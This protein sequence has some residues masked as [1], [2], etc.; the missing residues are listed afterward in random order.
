MQINRINRRKI[1]IGLR[2]LVFAALGMLCL[3]PAA[4]EQ[5]TVNGLFQDKAIVT[6]DGRQRVL[7]KGKKSP[8]GALLIEANSKRAI[9]EIDGERK[10]YRMGSSRIG[11]NFKKSASGEKI[12]LL[13]DASGGYSVTGSIN[14]SAVSFI[15]DTG[16]TLVSM[17]SNVA[18]RLGI[19]F[20]LIGRESVSLTASGT[21]KIYIVNLRKVRV[22][23]IEL[24]NVQ[25]AV[26]D[27]DFPL[28]TLLGMSFLGELNMKREG[29]LLELEKKY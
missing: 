27:G 11:G 25:G 9:I 13:P 16:A 26:H 12:T 8:E 14:G 6:I 5:I 10:E 22:G 4:L 21:S 24:Q 2:P 23:A 28:V 18:R 29:R 20:K 1:R 19:D 17:N 7:K 15:V 3:Q